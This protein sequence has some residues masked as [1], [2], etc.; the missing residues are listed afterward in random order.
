MSI[1]TWRLCA[2]CTTRD[3]AAGEEARI[4]GVVAESRTRERV[5]HHDGAE[6]REY[7]VEFRL[8]PVPENSARG[9]ETRAAEGHRMGGDAGKPI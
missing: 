6:V 3:E 2:V 8:A 4:A 1:K 9:A 7:V 5:F